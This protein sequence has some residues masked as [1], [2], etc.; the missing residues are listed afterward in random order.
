MK[1]IK[2][3]ISNGFLAALLFI[4][5]LFYSWAAAA[6]A[7]AVLLL[8]SDEWMRKMMLRLLAALF[9]FALLSA[10]NGLFMSAVDL[11]RILIPV[12]YAVTNTVNGVL[13]IVEYICMLL[14][15]WNAYKGKAF[16]FGFLEKIVDSVYQRDN[17]GAKA[18]YCMKCG[19]PMNEEDGFCQKCGAKRV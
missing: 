12:P 9:V 7:L 2:L 18:G 14:M 11:I 8:S 1:N 6:M 19:N 10:V 3:P 5:G 13:A 15:A 16:T 17:S 4:I